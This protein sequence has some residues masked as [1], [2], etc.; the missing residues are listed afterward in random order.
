[1]SVFNGPPVLKLFDGNKDVQTGLHP[2]AEGSESI[3]LVPP[4]TPRPPSPVR[5]AALPALMAP[6]AYSSVQCVEVC[7]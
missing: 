5:I 7:K 6:G 2:M 4:K 3:P 1:M